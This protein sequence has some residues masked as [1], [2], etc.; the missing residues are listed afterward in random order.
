MVALASGGVS[1]FSA[2]LGGVTTPTRYNFCQDPVVGPCWGAFGHLGGNELGTIDKYGNWGGGNFTANILKLGTASND[3]GISR[4]G[5]GKFAFGNGGQ[6][7]ASGTIY[8]Q[9]LVLSGSSAPSG[10]AV[11]YKADHSLGYCATAFTGT[12]PTCT[13]K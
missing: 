8:S 2:S 1:V 9:K 13:C 3:T 5:A 12:P 7:D 4:M 10:A 6:G 11:C